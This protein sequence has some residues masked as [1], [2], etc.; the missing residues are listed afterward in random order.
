VDQ[1][2][3]LLI[4]LSSSPFDLRKAAVRRDMIRQN[5][6]KHARYF[7]YVNQV[8]GNDELIFDGHSIG[9]APDGAQIVRAREFAEDFV[10]YDVPCGGGTGP[11]PVVR[12]VS[13]SDEEAAYGALV[14]GL[15]DY[16]RKCGFRSAVLGLSGGI[17][18]ALT[19]CLAADALGSENVTG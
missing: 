7:F 9:I 19:A 17:D 10:V 2:A 14:L 3:Q 5:A 12:Q 16:A 18:S 13:T 1:R 6:V 8:G 15:R 4:N 11:A